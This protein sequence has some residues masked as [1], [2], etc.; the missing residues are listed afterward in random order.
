MFEL[1][2][3]RRELT[4]RGLLSRAAVTCCSFFIAAISQEESWTCV[5]LSVSTTALGPG[6]PRRLGAMKPTTGKLKPEMKQVS[7][8]S[9]DSGPLP[10][11]LRFDYLRMSS[12]SLVYRERALGVRSRLSQRDREGCERGGRVEG[13]QEEEA[14]G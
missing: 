8:P 7:P 10:S 4:P 6:R 2:V 1:W 14:K 12:H 5:F 13:G 11:P 3:R 9:D